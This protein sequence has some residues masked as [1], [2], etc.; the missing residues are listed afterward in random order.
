MFEGLKKFKVIEA[1]NGYRVGTCVAFNG[2]DAQ[3]YAKYIV[4]TDKVYNVANIE[5]KE[6]EEKPKRKVVRRGKK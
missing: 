2:A 4:S 3:K 5:V 1:F 6:V